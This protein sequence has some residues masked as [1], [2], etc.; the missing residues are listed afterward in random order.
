MHAAVL[1]LNRRQVVIALLLGLLA[2]AAW[3]YR[4]TLQPQPG[5]AP[6]AER[7][8][9]YI[10]EDLTAVAMDASGRPD[11]RIETP[12]LRHYPDDGSSELRLPVL[13]VFED[14]K[15]VWSVR[16]DTAWISADGDEVLLEGRV[17]VHRA[18]SAG[19]AAVDLESSELLVLPEL[20]YAET[21]RFVELES[22][23]DWVTAADGMQAWLGDAPRT[24]FF[25]RTRASFDVDRAGSAPPSDREAQPEPVLDRA[26]DRAP[27]GESNRRPAAGHQAGSA[28]TP[29]PLA[30]D[31]D[32]E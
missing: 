5:V 20:D 25:G 29:A 17:M 10:V 6:A 28:A 3:W 21:D 9:D 8:P 11:R 14:D 23:G 27:S 16:S 26:L 30:A 2:L 18:A 24:R 13:R 22:D 32:R 19:Q 4:T 1:T 15:L 7:R 31:R 12:E